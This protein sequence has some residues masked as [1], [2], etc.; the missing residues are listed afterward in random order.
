MSNY[1]PL[2][3][4]L[5][6]C[7]NGEKYLQEAIDSIYSQT[8]NNW[9]IIFIDNCSTDNS[10]K[11]AKSYDQGRLKYYK[12][13]KNISLGAARNLGIKFINGKFLAFLDTDDVWFSN[14]LEKQL[15]VIGEDIAFV[16]GPV[17][18]MN[19]YGKPLRE[20]KI[21]K[22]KNFKS[23]L[24]RYDINM[25][26]TLINLKIVD[27]K[28]NEE[29]SYCPDFELFMKIVSENH[30]FISINS[31]L[32]K[33][34]IHSNSM[35]RKTINIQMNEVRLVLNQLKKN[36]FLYNK[37]KKSFDICVYKFDCLFKA[38]KMI[39]LKSFYSASKELYFLSK[40]SKK[41]LILS[42]LLVIPVLNKF[43]YN[44]ILYKYI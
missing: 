12:T 40:I 29:L 34:R 3:S 5:M 1:Q 9:E 20:T 19:E 6:N 4:I 41:Y 35:S 27:V 14:K 13:K 7:Y 2:V 33:Y 22:E 16:Y 39:D 30:N 23:L 38:K 15:N 31:S 26:S 18:Q 36:D 8:Y 42:I 17:I 32:V 28:F 24:E 11:I 37:Y 25:H 43:L 10:A 21:N 44:K